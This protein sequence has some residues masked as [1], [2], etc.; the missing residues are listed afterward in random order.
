[1]TDPFCKIAVR[2][3]PRG[4]HN[5]IDSVAQSA[6]GDF[7]MKVRVTAPPED[8]R[9]NAAVEELIAHHLGLAKSRVSVTSGHTARIKHITVWA[10]PAMVKDKL[11]PLCL[12]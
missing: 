4:G 10:D 1:M 5:R 2:V 9:A 6:R 8:G 7:L 12:A 3:T 11:D